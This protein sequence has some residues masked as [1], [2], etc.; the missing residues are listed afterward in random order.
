MQN[1]FFL[2]NKVCWLITTI[3]WLF[4]AAWSNP[5]IVAQQPDSAIVVQP[6]AILHSDIPRSDC[7]NDTIILSSSSQGVIPVVISLASGRAK[8]ASSW[9]LQDITL[10]SLG[11]GMLNVPLRTPTPVVVRF[12]GIAPVGSTIYDTLIVHWG[13]AGS[14]QTRTIPLQATVTPVWAAP[15]DT[16]FPSPIVFGGVDSL[17]VLAVNRTSRP[18]KVNTGRLDSP[19]GDQGFAVIAPL[20]SIT[21][22]PLQS[23]PIRVQF[24][25]NSQSQSLVQ[26]TIIINEDDTLTEL[27]IGVQARIVPRPLQL[28]NAL[29]QFGAVKLGNCKTDSFVVIGGNTAFAI[30]TAWITG[31]SGLNDP[32]YQILLPTQFPVQ[33]VFS[34]RFVVQFCPDSTSRIMDTSALLNLRCRVNGQAP[35]NLTVELR[36]SVEESM[37]PTI[38]PMKLDF[39]A[40]KLDTC[41]T[42]TLTITGDSIYQILRAEFWRSNQI[43]TRFTLI[44]PQ[45]LPI[46]ITP[47]GVRLVIRFCPDSTVTDTTSM[48]FLSTNWSNTVITIPLTGTSVGQ[49]DPPIERSTIRLSG[50]TGQAGTTFELP[51]TLSAPIRADQNVQSVFFRMRMPARAL[52]PVKV[53]TTTGTAI[54]HSYSVA[55]AADTATGIL[56]VNSTGVITGEIIARIEFMALTTGYPK[57]VIVVD[58]VVVG[59]PVVAIDTTSGIVELEGCEIGKSISFTKRARIISIR[60]SPITQAST[61]HYIAPDGTQPTVRLIDLLG[62]T[63]QTINLPTGTGR[64]ELYRPDLHG[65]A[66]GIYLLELHVGS[67]R[68]VIP[69]IIAE[70]GG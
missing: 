55:Y 31:N 17:T 60:P 10:D 29:L 30:D 59:S 16:A 63:A 21:I 18:I 38:V 20:D 35:Q 8:T 69:V 56:T 13:N 70:G 51:I 2:T 28:S 36:G 7:R 66:P 45:P 33:N 58:S 50:A 3:V 62:G 5:S 43:D 52:Y 14:T 25:A 64:E 32:R 12:C 44:A 46:N 11:E 37:P 22:N 39:G 65:L 26:N 34:A 23:L 19:F 9:S 6:S 41:V 47:N 24:T 27:R 61:L 67:E 68:N 48:L 15:A 53:T 4:A 40:V 54:P 42:D 1:P 49:P 57:T